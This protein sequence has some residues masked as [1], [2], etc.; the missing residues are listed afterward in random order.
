VDPRRGGEKRDRRSPGTSQSVGSANISFP[1]ERSNL[2]EREKKIQSGENH[3][4]ASEIKQKKNYPAAQESE[5]SRKVKGQDRKVKTEGEERRIQKRR[6][7]KWGVHK[8]NKLHSG[9]V[10]QKDIKKHV[11]GRIT[12]GLTLS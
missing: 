4:S 12:R 5:T 7:Q 6:I 8:P 11:A 9:T 3:V 2:T 1:T 10:L